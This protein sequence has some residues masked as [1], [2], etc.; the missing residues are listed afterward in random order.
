MALDKQI[1]GEAARK[2]GIDPKILWGLYGTETSFGKNVSTSSAGAVGPF[3]FEPATAK[4][5]G[6]N[7]YDFKSAAFGAAR[8]LSQ[9]KGRGIG[10]MLSAYNAGPAGGYQS[11]YVNTTLQNAKTYGGATP[12]PIPQAK[13]VGA[14]TAAS[15][16]TEEVEAP[17]AKGF[18]QL[19]KLLKAE[20][21][22]AP[23][24]GLIQAKTEPVTR[25]IP[26]TVP[27]ASPQDEPHLA[28]IIQEADHISEAHV[29][30]LWGGG[31][32]ARVLPGGKVTPL[33][34]SGAVS[35]ALGINPKVA[36][37]FESWG[38]PGKGP[39]LTIWAKSTHVLMEV[40]GK[41]WGTSASNP[42][43]GAGWI[44]PGVITPEYLKGFTPRHPAS[45][46]ATPTNGGNVVKLPLRSVFVPHG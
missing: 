31:H 7:P 8:Y 41:F 21:A 29:P 3:Q 40:D 45:E 1:V 36:S 44:K 27:K 20:G 25:T 30:Y 13:P 4:S 38:A 11:G 37:E 34:C 35:A 17:H 26:S 2:Y 39:H 23:L 14:P 6:V 32:A 24:T 5:M 22:P 9:Y 42:G 46:Q 18:E 12:S 19:G 16:K 15:T 10:G 28:S 43:G 33:D